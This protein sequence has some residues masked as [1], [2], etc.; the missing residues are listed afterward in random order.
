M[1][2]WAQKAVISGTVSDATTGKAVAGA[3]VTAGK[4]SVV[5]NDDGFFTL[6][7]DGAVTEVAI[8]HVG[9]Q[10]QHAKVDAQN[11]SPLRIRL[12]PVTIQL[13][14]VLVMADNARMLLNMA[15][16]RI[17]SNYSSQPEL[18]RCFYRET[19]MKRQHYICVAEGV[20]DMYKTDY[21]QG[22]ERDRVAI[23]K[24]RR[25]ISPKQGDTLSV[26]VLGGPVTPI[27]LDLVKNRELLLNKEEL[28]CYDV[29]MEVPTSINNRMQYVVSIA[30]HRIMPYPLYFG[31]LYIDQETFSFT[32]AE[33]SL[34][35][36]NRQKATEMMLVK[37]P[38][39]V[40]FRPKELSLL[41]DYQLGD[42][43]K[44]RISYLRTTFRFNCD[45][46]RRLFATSFAA[47]CEMVVTSKDEG[48]AQPIRGRD[49]FDQHDAFYD[50]VDYF[51]DPAFW[52][53]YNIIEP[54]ETLDRAVQRLLKK[55]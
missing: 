25:L 3:S 1:S 40:R 6:K 49:S 15:I 48:E 32:R 10:T 14:E 34:D 53:N 4:W 22:T 29:K 12:R 24:G 50:K 55:Y 7:T 43:G 44:T 26:K 8:S 31:R 47:F 36:S 41:V 54:T 45:W 37:K 5:T 17:P 46:R 27:V 21:Q 20:V 30:P 35:M 33:L 18:F 16:S 2:A 38:A 28:D 42:D 9:F 19:A 52:E 23:S 11:N 51:R 39:G 13:D